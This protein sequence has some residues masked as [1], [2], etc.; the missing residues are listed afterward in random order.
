MHDTPTK[1]LFKRDTRAFSHGCIRLSEPMEMLRVFSEV[2]SNVNLGSSRSI[3][4]GSKETN[5]Y[6]AKSV[7]VDVVYLT[8]WV[9]PSGELQF[10]NDIY[11]YDKLQLACRVR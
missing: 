3:L 5:V 7:P 4:K 2:D 9:N 10:R 8:A 6:L 1:R 11:G